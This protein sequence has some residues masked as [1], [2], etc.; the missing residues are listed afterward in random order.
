MTVFDVNGGFVPPQV[1]R[2]YVLIRISSYQL[3]HSCVQY[4]YETI[5]SISTII[6]FDCIRNLLLVLCR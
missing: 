1:A 5:L 4:I 3:D 6:K 2:T